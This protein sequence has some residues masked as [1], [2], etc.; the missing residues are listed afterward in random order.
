M[1]GLLMTLAML[2]RKAAGYPI[3]GSLPMAEAVEK[4]Y[5][6]LGRADQLQRQGGKDTGGKW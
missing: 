3:G 1:V 4:R 2:H 6:E 5:L